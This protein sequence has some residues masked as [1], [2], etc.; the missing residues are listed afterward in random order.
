MNITEQQV[1]F[2]KTL[3]ELADK[4]DLTQAQYNAAIAK[5]EAVGDFLADEYSFLSRYNPIIISQGS[6]RIGTAIRPIKGE[7]FDVDLTCRLI[8]NSPYIQAEVKKLI[9]DRFYESE[10]YKRM[11]DEKRRCWRLN[12]AE[13]SKFHLDIVPAVPDDYQLLI[14]LGVPE[15]F[16]KHAVSITDNES[17]NYNKLSS[18]LP[19]SNPEGY[20]LWFIEI[21]KRY[22]NRIGDNLVKALNEHVEEVPYF[23]IRTPLQR[24]IQLMKHHK[25][26]MFGEDDDKPVS[27]IITTL[28]ARAYEDVMNSL[29][30]VEFYDFLRRIVPAMR[31]HIKIKDGVKWV[32]NPVNPRENFADKWQEK[33]MKELKFMQWLSAFEEVLTNTDLNDGIYGLGSTLKKSF[34][35]SIVNEAIDSLG[36][37]TRLERDK[38]RLRV[39]KAGLLGA[40]GTAIPSHTFDGND[41]EG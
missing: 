28:A 30:P 9:K 23:D 37:A 21:M 5:Y 1:F 17:Y 4:I 6:F 35:E 26:V 34:N 39:S 41:D 10:V 3:A 7:E 36:D 11:L 22:A 27:V 18:D 40:A 13:S 32:E 20:A 33:P 16:A 12:Y 2:G 38:N 8:C 29:E 24:A 19:K 15:R 31:K 25:E 14:A